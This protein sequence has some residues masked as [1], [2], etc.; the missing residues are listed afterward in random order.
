VRIQVEPGARRPQRKA[1]LAVLGE[2][3]NRL[4]R[5]AWDGPAEPEPV[6]AATAMRGKR[7][8]LLAVK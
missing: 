5:F 6:T 2:L 4:E 7:L 3:G 1:L 8:D